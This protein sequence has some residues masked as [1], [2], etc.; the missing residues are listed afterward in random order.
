MTKGDGTCVPLFKDRVTGFHWLAERTHAS[1]TILGHRELVKQL[2]KQPNMGGVS[3]EY[4]L[5]LDSSE[6][7]T[8]MTETEPKPSKMLT[9]YEYD[10]YLDRIQLGGGKTLVNTCDKTVKR[11]NPTKLDMRCYRISGKWWLR[12][13]T[14]ERPKRVRVSKKSR[15]NDFCSVTMNGEGV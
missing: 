12:T 10:T 6:Q 13:L 2:A 14:N 3:M 8:L 15:R 5:V 9:Q 4:T 1:P 7:S 11:L